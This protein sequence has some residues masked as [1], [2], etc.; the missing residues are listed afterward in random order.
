MVYE[1]DK[2]I[3]DLYQAAIGN[4]PEHPV[5]FA[6]FVIAFYA[7]GGFGVREVNHEWVWKF[8]EI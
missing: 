3:A 6:Q 5:S 2:G 7:K 1:T 8:S 4:K